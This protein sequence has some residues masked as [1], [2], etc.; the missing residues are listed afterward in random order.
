[1][2]DFLKRRDFIIA[3]CGAALWPL[4]ARAQ[5]QKRMPLV[6]V[7]L[8]GAEADPRE[9]RIAAAFRN[10]LRD[11]GLIEGENIVLDL[12]FG[13]ADPARIERLAAELVARTP[14]A[15]YCETTVPSRAMKQATRTIPIVFTGVADPIGGGL[16]ASIAR[17]GGNITGFSPYEPA[18]GGQ[19]VQLLK[20]MSPSIT[21]IA[22]M[23]NPDTS[24]YSFFM[25]DMEAAAARF[26]QPLERAI[27]RD[28]DDIERAIAALA[29]GN[30]GLVA[31]PDSFAVRH[32]AR[33][34]DAAMRHRVPVI[35]FLK[36]FAVEG[37]LMSYGT[38]FDDMARRAG[39]YIDLILKGAR[40][41]DLPVQLPTAFELAINL[42]TAKALG[43]DPPPLLLARAD[44]VIE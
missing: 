36:Y 43:I 26:G 23:F 34:F 15:I 31:V 40:P 2:S 11:A 33:I 20:E 16:V 44:E 30:S 13:A 27:V 14:D 1:M 3:G 28:P 6:A 38:D 9:Q 39:T 25:P 21:R 22:A 8:G 12:R 35:Y 29:G 32:R 24:P 5:Q 19:W 17:P 10:G 37:G 4:A 41:A 7:L 42:N 18:M